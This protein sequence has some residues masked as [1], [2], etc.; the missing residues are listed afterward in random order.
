MD[1]K[2]EILDYPDRV[3]DSFTG[4]TLFM[5]GATGF[6]GK[7][8]VEKLLRTCDGIVKIYLLVRPKKGKDPNERINEQ[9]AGPVRITC[10]FCVSICVSVMS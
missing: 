3:A 5:T 1:Q 4:K 6:L 2:A 7:V 8:L 9:F 10:K